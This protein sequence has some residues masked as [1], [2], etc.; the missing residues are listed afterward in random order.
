[1]A[2]STNGATTVESVVAAAA[3]I[4][5]CG[6]VSQAKEALRFAEKVVAASL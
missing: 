6:G 2:P 4:K 3:F 1:M 5:S